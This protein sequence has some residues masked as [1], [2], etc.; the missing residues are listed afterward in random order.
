MSNADID[1]PTFLNSQTSIFLKKIARKQ[2]KFDPNQLLTLFKHLAG[3]SCA[4]LN[5]PLDSAFNTII[6]EQLTELILINLINR[7]QSLTPFIIDSLKR[8]HALNDI[9]S[10]LTKCFE[11]KHKFNTEKLAEEF[12]ELLDTIT[13]RTLLTVA[14]ECLSIESQR[15]FGTFIHKNDLPIPLSYYIGDTIDSAIY[16]VNFNCLIEVL[17]LTTHRSYIQ[18]GSN[19]SLGFGKTSII[20]FIFNDKRSALLY[21]KREDSIHRSSCIDVIIGSAN[22]MSYVIFDVHGPVDHELNL[23][24]IR[25][26]QLYATI[27]VLYVTP[28]DLPDEN[29]FLKLMITT[30]SPSPTIV[31]IF[32]EK[33]DSE[34]LTS[35]KHEEKLIDEFQNYA[36][37]NDWR[38]NIQWAI[39]PKFSMT[40]T[41]GDNKIRR[42]ADRLISKFAELFQ[43]FDQVM[44]ERPPFR[45]I[46][47]IQSAYHING[48]NGQCPIPVRTSKLEI[49]N[50]LENLFENLSDQSE[51]LK[52]ITPVSYF[53][54][55]SNSIRKRL[56]EVVDCAHESKQLSNQWKQ[57]EIERRKCQVLN[58]YAKFMIN[59]LQESPYICIVITELYLE[60][61]RLR[62]TPALE[63]EK[64][65]LKK[66]AFECEHKLRLEEQRQP[67]GTNSNIERLRVQL[68]VLKERITAKDAQ[69]A[70]VDLTLGLMIDELFA[71]YDYLHDENPSLLEQYASNFHSVADKI[72]ELVYRGFAIHVLRNRPLLCQSNLMEMCLKRLRVIEGGPLA[73]LT[74]IGEQSSAKS[75]LLNATFGCN[76]RVSPGRCTIG[77][78]LA[79]AYYRTMTIVILDS[80][81][82]LSLEE[83]GS[84]FDNQMITM[85][86]LSSHIVLINHKG[87]FSSNLEGLIGMSLYAKLQLQSSPLK[88][89]LI[90][91]LRDQMDRNKGVFVEQL[92]KLRTNLH[93]SSRFLHVSIDNELEMGD[94][95]LALLPSAISEDTNTDLNLTQQ[96]RNQTFPAKINELR[97]QI[98]RGLTEQTVTNKFG[99]RN[100]DYFYKKLGTNWNSI[101]ELGQGLLECRTLYELSVTNELKEI[102]KGIVIEKYEKLL[103]NGRKTLKGLLTSRQNQYQLIPDIYM[104]EVIQKGIQ[105]LDDL[106]TDLVRE[107]LLQFD[108]STRQSNFAELRVNIRKNIEPSIRCHRQGLQEQ[109]E[110]DV[111]TVARESATV[112][113]QNQLLESAKEFFERQTRTNV[114]VDELNRALASRH[115]E[116]KREFER[117]IDAMRKTE[118][119]IIITILNNYNRLVRSR[120]ANANRNDIYNRCPIFDP[121]SYNEKRNSLE[122]MFQLAMLHLSSKQKDRSFFNKLIGFF[123]SPGDDY[124]DCLPWFQD[125]GDHHQNREIFRHIIEDLIP[126]LHRE[127]VLM[128]SNIKFA[129]S[130]PQTII[131]LVNYVDNSMNGQQSSIQKYYRSINLPQITPDLIFIALRI[132]IDEAIRIAQVK[133]N[134]MRN[135]LN[136]LETWVANIK[137]Q[138]ILI[139]DSDQQ[140]RK[141]SD[142]FLNQL[143][144]ETMT[145][146]KETVHTEIGL[147]IR[148]NSQID[149]EKIARNAYD[150]SIGSNPPIGNNIMKYILDINRYYMELALDNIELSAQNIVMSQILKLQKLISDC[151]D[152]AVDVVRNHQCLNVQQVYR[153]ITQALQS[154][155]PGFKTEN[156]VGISAKIEQPQ[157]FRQRFMRITDQREVLIQRITDHKSDFDEEAKRACRALITQRLGCQACCPGC[158]TKCDN[159]EL[160]HDK[161][162]SAHHIAMAFKGWRW[163]STKYPTLELCYQQW[164]NASS[165]IVGGVTFSPRR[166]Y[167][168]Q[169][170]QQ[171]LDDIDEK[172]KTGDM[173]KDNMPPLDQRRAW[174]AVRKALVSHYQT[175]DQPSYDNQCYPSSVESLLAGYQPQWT[176]LS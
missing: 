31:C 73:V 90:F 100:F 136:G 37:Q 117:S 169:R 15:F 47:A 119:D 154:I 17:C 34:T 102:A 33:F 155:V 84:I 151:I 156:L 175:K 149:P 71:L 173:C 63:V 165:L 44:K 28:D 10:V 53:R 126:Y 22:K 74:V 162:K 144:E 103:M 30:T 64:K 113:V 26:I 39:V 2:L 9:H 14:I 16:K 160:D 18:V 5:G 32:D 72:A 148:V 120:G 61:W 58:P 133:H 153:S 66:E 27:Q 108:S 48:T 124:R 139:R 95:N 121:N 91:V 128:L 158:G 104:K 140:G 7:N 76:F 78:Y 68:K 75:S 109:F 4:D 8:C 88:P 12:L 49:E 142:D 127:L 21:N 67:K 45:S 1:I 145:L 114:D 20:P 83:S 168:E 163:E 57:I 56:A 51:N 86:V 80:E 97:M 13:T 146:C 130:D 167:Y 19:H 87:E 125:D 137:E 62:F 69:L 115:V 134:E 77:M 111:Y 107:A 138:F 85:A 50:I 174:M 101:N 25:A 40:H 46:F 110:E 106:T 150:N 43:A 93:N 112:Q 164:Q 96:W 143:F 55:Q 3:L 81:G 141:F 24:L 172:A 99:Y 52:I 36:N 6:D 122:K 41:L 89:K 132:L 92:I 35:K 159:V 176:Y 135:A 116:L 79:V 60:K 123:K 59:L 118:E 147:K 94:E 161:H 98:I 171:W 23:S 65:S 131:N 170:A 38:T 11:L 42:R 166:T 129:Y 29:N 105:W 70:N 54:S 152:S 82:L 157:Q